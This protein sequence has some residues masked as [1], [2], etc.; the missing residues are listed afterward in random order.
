MKKLV[1][2]MVKMLSIIRGMM[3]EISVDSAMRRFAG[4][5]FC[6]SACGAMG[7]S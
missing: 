6:W 7:A 5:T 3:M 1:R 4:A 2:A